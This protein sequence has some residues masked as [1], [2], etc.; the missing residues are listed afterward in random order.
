V[1]LTNTLPAN[2][3]LVTFSPS[4][5]SCASV[6]G[7]I[8]CSLGD[9]AGGTNATVTIVVRPA[10]VGTLT[11]TAVVARDGG[12]ANLANNTAVT[13]TPVSF[14]ALSI[15][16]ASVVEGDA[17]VTQAVFTVVLSGTHTTT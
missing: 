4:Q 12:E 13:L 2:A 17:G 16:N 8:R 3:A 9:L 6:E 5:G 10:A 1:T 15:G 14:A 11:N 7:S